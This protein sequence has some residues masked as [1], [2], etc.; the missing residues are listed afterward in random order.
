VKAALGVAL[1]ALLLASG[2]SAFDLVTGDGTNVD[3]DGHQHAGTLDLTK[4]DCGNYL[5]G[6][7]E[8][9][10]SRSS[11]NYTWQDNTTSAAAAGRAPDHSWV[12]AAGTK[13][14]VWD[15]G[16]A[17]D[18]VVV[19]PAIDHDPVP[20]EAFEYTAFG[21]DSSDAGAPS[22]QGDI[23]VI[24]DSGFSAWIA[25]DY[26]ARWTFSSP[27]RF[28]HIVAGGPGA[29]VS[30][31][32]AE[33]DAVCSDLAPPASGE[34]ANAIPKAGV[35]E[36]KPP[37]STTFVPLTSSDQ[38]PVG[39]V[40]D[41]TNGTVTLATADTA[42]KVQTAAFHRGEFKLLQRASA[43]GLTEL[44]LTGGRS[45]KACSVSR[46]AFSARKKVSKAVLRGLFGKGHGIYK[47]SGRHATLTI[48]GTS[49][50]VQDRCDGTFVK[51]IEGRGDVVDKVRHRIVHLRA[52]QT[53]LARTR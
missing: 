32:E 46:A 24:Y 31:G 15:M 16:R 53:Y 49:F 26:S 19:L 44:Q 5:S 45:P 37:G 25:D 2:A 20:G 30:D 4:V 48:R 23:S 50:L 34:T 40:V 43:S 17:V 18:S 27:H 28:V 38:I 3:P 51:V 41:T 9:G 36:V 52:G 7:R 6:A 33:I 11:T 21:S 35:V 12:Q 22:S 8:A 14:V 42:G 39:S 13:E 29:M 47:T 1:L 10:S